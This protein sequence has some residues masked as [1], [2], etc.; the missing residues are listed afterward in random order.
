MN[1]RER[2][3][4]DTNIWL[5]AFIARDPAKSSAAATLLQGSSLAVSVQVINEVCVNLKPKASLGEPD[6]RDLIESFYAKCL[7][8]PA[9]KDLLIT[10]SSLRDRYSVSFWDSLIVANAIQSGA[11][12]LYSEDMQH[13]LDIEGRLKIVNP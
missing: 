4:V 10:A 12:L 13:G 3:F 6:L 2:V 7:V 11:A 9:G 8:V 1:G 5:Y